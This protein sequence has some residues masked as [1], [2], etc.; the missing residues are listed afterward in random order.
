MYS[1]IERTSRITINYLLRYL[2]QF[3]LHSSCRRDA[4]RRFA[5]PQSTCPAR[6]RIALREETRDFH[7]EHRGVALPSRPF[8]RST[9]FLRSFPLLSTLPHLAMSQSE[10][11]HIYSCSRINLYKAQLA[12]MQF[13]QVSFYFENIFMLHMKY[14]RINYS[15]L[16]LFALKSIYQLEKY[17]YIWFDTRFDK[18]FLKIL[19]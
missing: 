7:C 5:T 16:W 2:S 17:I 3:I 10:R 1:V 12:R 18:M 11:M 14:L 9:I 8:L 6:Y 19:I 15:D 13:V 4:T